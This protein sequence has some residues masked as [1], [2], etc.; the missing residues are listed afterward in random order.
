VPSP[1]LGKPYIH[2]DT[3]LDCKISVIEEEAK[4]TKEKAKYW[5]QLALRL[6][7]LMQHTIYHLKQAP[8]AQV[9]P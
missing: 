2:R 9:L 8:T 7:P 1:Y 6:S 4:K 5:D 3:W